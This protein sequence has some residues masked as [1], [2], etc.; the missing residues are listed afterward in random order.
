MGVLDMDCATNSFVVPAITAGRAQTAANVHVP[1][2][3][4]GATWPTLQDYAH[5]SAECSNRGLCD[6]STGKCT[7]MDGFGGSACERMTCNANCNG[8]G[9]CYSLN[10]LASQTRDENS[11]SFTYETELGSY[12]VWD[13]NKIFGCKCDPLYKGYDCSIRDTASQSDDPLTT[14][15]VNEV[16][17]VKCIATEG[18][19]NLYY[20][21]YPS[22][23]IAHDSS[24]DT[25]RTALLRFPC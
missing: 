18:N 17:L 24:A 13:A 1:S 22:A 15:Q 5:A 20:K 9:K 2:A 11:L 10:K 25:I 6:R 12:G 8:N 16:Q 21:G 3:T 14:G 19:F 7:C 23:T 4:P